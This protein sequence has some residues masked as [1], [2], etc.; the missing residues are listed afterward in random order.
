M[1]NLHYLSPQWKTWTQS[2]SINGVWSQMLSDWHLF[3]PDVSMHPEDEEATLRVLLLPLLSRSASASLLRCFPWAQGCSTFG[4]KPFV[5]LSLWPSNSGRKHIWQVEIV[6]AHVHRHGW[7]ECL[8]VGFSSSDWLTSSNLAAL[9][10]RPQN[11]GRE[12]Y[13]R[14][15]Y[16]FS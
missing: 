15:F 6:H 10:I 3:L 1:E 7:A 16:S 14:N 9:F 12:C 2:G 13:N 11:G 5:F 8:L 4:S